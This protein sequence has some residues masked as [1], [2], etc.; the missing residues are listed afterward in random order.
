MKPMPTV[1][2]GF[3][4]PDR[5]VVGT[6]GRP[7][8]RTFYLQTREGSRL[9]SVRVEKEQSAAL[10]DK[11]EQILN[12][13]MTEDRNALRIPVDAP[14]ELVDTDPLEPV[15][16]QFRTGTLGL[17]WD[18]STAQIVIQAYSFPEIDDDV[19]PD[20]IDV[21]ELEPEEALQ[22]R[23]PVGTARAFVQAT[24]AVVGA[25]RP[26]CPL[27]GQPLDPDGHVCSTSDEL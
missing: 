10:A 12:Q 26:T 2:H 4:W 13:L 6:I 1:V 5:V 9:I 16:E 7:G 25:G 20:S 21:D 8:S 22:V 24:R 14:P 17:G 3:D 18:P 15:E 19:D 23:M 11:I 27:C